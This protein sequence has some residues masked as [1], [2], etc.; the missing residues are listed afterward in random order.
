MP[1]ITG[2]TADR[3]QEII[4]STIVDADIVDGNLILAKHDGSTY[5]AGQTKSYDASPIGSVITHTSQVIPPEYLVANGQVVSE[6]SYPQLA[7]FAADE[8]LA[9]NALWAISGIAPS[10]SIT[11]PNLTDRFLFSK[12]TK[13]FGAKS[14]EENH[15]LTTGEAAQ[16][17]VSNGSTGTNGDHN[18]EIFSQNAGSSTATQNW[19]NLPMWRDIGTQ[20]EAYPHTGNAG[21]HSHAVSIPGASAASAHNNMPPYC[22]LAFLIKAKGVAILGD[23]LIGPPGA[24][25]PS[26]PTGPTGSTGSTGATGPTGIQG[27]PGATNAIYSDIWSWTTSTTAASSSGQIGLNAATWAATT[28]I[29]INEQ[30]KDGRNVSV[31]A[32]P[33][34]SVGDQL[35]LQHKT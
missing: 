13:A 14:G 6:S 32:F 11:L 20:F 3:M 18:H 19:P 12:G 22:V 10:R 27:P 21:D 31:L 28:Q 4:D 25:G 7:T 9:G 34:F 26:G 17:A 33:R 35:Y 30:T 29:N 2:L 5:D 8:V 15:L 23:T 1:T 16:K 24:A